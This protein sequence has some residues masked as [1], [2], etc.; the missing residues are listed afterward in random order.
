[1]TDDAFIAALLT[2]LASE[3]RP[4]GSSRNAELAAHLQSL[5]A[6]FGYA[7]EID[8]LPF[9]AWEQDADPLVELSAADD[10]RTAD[11]P[12]PVVWSAP[13]DVVGRILA[14]A[15]RPSQVLTFD[16]YPWDVLP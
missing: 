9:T 14:A 10:H 12:M 5:Y 4:A 3:P 7:T 16:A 2:R 15:P 11:R 13:G 8:A 1:M 6:S